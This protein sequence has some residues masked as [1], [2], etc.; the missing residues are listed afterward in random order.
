[1][2]ILKI[3]FFF[4][5]KTHILCYT[6]IGHWKDGFYTLTQSFAS[7]AEALFGRILKLVYASEFYG[8][9]NDESGIEE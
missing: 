2:K 7:P 9:E 5:Y 3:R 6:I 1:M 8:G 4:I